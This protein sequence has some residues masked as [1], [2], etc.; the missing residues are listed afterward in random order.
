[1]L[2][3]PNDTMRFLLPIL[4]TKEYNNYF[5]FNDYYI[6]SYTSDINYPEMDNKLLL[7]Y[8]FIPEITYITFE[9]CIFDHPCYAGKYTYEREDI[10]VYAFDI[11]ENFKKDYND[12]G[13]RN[14]SKLSSDLKLNIAKM[15]T[16]HST[17]ELFKIITGNIDYLGEGFDKQIFNI[18]DYDYNDLYDQITD[19]L[20][21]EEGSDRDTTEVLV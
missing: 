4:Y 15:W 16:L 6:G 19:A 8:Q 14:F 9:E 20:S 7:V 17:D 10:I 18:E 12:V 11:P 1:M 2:V 3:K 5:F 13:N 21:A